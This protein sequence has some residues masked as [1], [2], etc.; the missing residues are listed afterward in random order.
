MEKILKVEKEVA[1]P[2]VEQNNGRCYVCVADIVGKPNYSLA[3]N[4][5]NHRVKT[6]CNKCS[7]LICK[8]HQQKHVCPSCSHVDA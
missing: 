5:L 3:N 1:A 2:T 6:K 4:A 8:K 7:G